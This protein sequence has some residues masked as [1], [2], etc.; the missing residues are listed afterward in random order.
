MIKIRF[1][2]MGLANAMVRGRWERSELVARC[3][4]V[5]GRECKFVGNLVDRMLAASKTAASVIAASNEIPPTA[6]DLTTWLCKDKGLRTASR[7]RKFSIGLPSIPVKMMPSP[8]APRL[9]GVPELVDRECLT[10]YLEIEPEE[11]DWFADQR[12]WNR[13]SKSHSLGHYRYRWIPRRSAGPPRLIEIPK[14]RLKRIQRRIVVGILNRIP[15]H[16]AAHGFCP[17]KRILSAVKPHVGRAF[18]LRM[19]LEN[20]FPTVSASQIMRIFRTAGYPSSISETLTGLCVN[21]TPEWVLDRS[22]DNRVGPDKG[23]F[24]SLMRGAH[25]PQGAPTSPAL[26][27]LAAF[28]IDGR[29]SQLAKAADI[30]YTRY[31]DDLIFSGRKWAVGQRQRFERMVQKITMECSFRIQLKKTRWMR[32]GERQTALGIVLNQTPNVDRKQYDQLQAIVHNCLIH[33]PDSQCDHDLTE[34]RESLAGRIASHS[35]RR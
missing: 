7:G 6:D 27:N 35:S 20:I 8:G 33:G 25:L 12:G 28:Q 34:F 21:R 22:P 11:L 15:P 29:L 1:A 13:K 26:A 10:T 9:W 16:E 19:D 4:D 5:L 18:V 3:N 30:H 14:F 32:P 2:A 24:E 31:A 17:G 23:L